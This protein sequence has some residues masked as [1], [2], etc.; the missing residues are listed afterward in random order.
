MR[1][2][3]ASA[4]NVVGKSACTDSVPVRAI[5][6]MPAL[7]GWFTSSN[8]IWLKGA[9]DTVPVR[10]FSVPAF[11]VPERLGTAW[12]D[13]PAP[14]RLFKSAGG[15]LKA[16]VFAVRVETAIVPAATAEGDVTET[17]SAPYGPNS[18]P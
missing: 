9:E 12:K 4:A 1:V 15:T 8:T 11:V 10:T 17:I 3:P 14:M 16:Q 6:L 2:V 13:V 5:K 18:G 7:Q